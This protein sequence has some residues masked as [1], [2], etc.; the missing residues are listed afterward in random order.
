[1]M[2]WSSAALATV[3][4]FLLQIVKKKKHC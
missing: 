2:L 3:A 1:M 4:Q